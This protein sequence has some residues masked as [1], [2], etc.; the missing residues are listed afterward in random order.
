MHGVG[1][2]EWKDG[3]RY[4]GE[5]LNDKKE[6]YGVYSWPDGRRYEG[7]WR[8]GMQH[9]EGRYFMPTG[10][11]RLGVW[12]TGKRVKWVEQEKNI[13]DLKRSFSSHVFN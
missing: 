8:D 9:G 5:Y 3:R 7:Y 1:V 11:C 6:G 4:E 10:G 2:F 12:E 13:D